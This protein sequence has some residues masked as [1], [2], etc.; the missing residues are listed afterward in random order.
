VKFLVGIYELKEDGTL[1]QP[2]PA[3]EQPKKSSVQHGKLT[4]SDEEIRRRNAALSYINS[5]P[6]PKR[7]K[8][9]DYITKRMAMVNF[10]EQALIKYNYYLTKINNHNVEGME[11]VVQP[12]FKRLDGYAYPVY[13]PEYDVELN[14]VQYL[15][16]GDR[17]F[18][19][20]AG[21]PDTQYMDFITYQH[22]KPEHLQV[23]I[24]SRLKKQSF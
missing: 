4:L 2:R 14:A 18:W 11:Q 20:F 3:A 15:K 6:N 21:E 23:L 8:V 16:M 13:F 10:S 12:L 19:K 7:Q 17:T 22:L 1:L 9:R 5:L 24:E